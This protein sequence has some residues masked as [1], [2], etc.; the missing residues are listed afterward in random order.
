MHGQ[1]H[2]KFEITYFG[3]STAQCYGFW[4]FISDGRKV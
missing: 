3:S 1:N 4:N 2:I